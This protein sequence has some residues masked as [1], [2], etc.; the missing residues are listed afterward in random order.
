MSAG[1]GRVPARRWRAA[2]F[3]P[4]LGLDLALP[5]RMHL[6]LSSGGPFAY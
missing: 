3:D 6:P 5:G 4:A 1:A 2:A